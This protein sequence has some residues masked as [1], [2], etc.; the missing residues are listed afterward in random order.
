MPR[1]ANPESDFK[2]SVE[3]VGTF[4]FA[5]RTMADEFAIQRKY[6]DLTGGG[7]ITQWLG[8]VGGWI[9]ALSVLTVKSPE[10]WDL[11]TMDPLSTKV[12][13]N[14]SRVFTALKDAED[15]FRGIT[16]ADGEAE[17]KAAGADD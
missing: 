10:G 12:Y 14:L 1:L 5:N 15:S 9:A 16:R 8:L 11:N 6:A 4:V 13:E 3:G 17:G 2:V 7:P